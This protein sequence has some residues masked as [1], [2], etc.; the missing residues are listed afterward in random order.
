MEEERLN[1][2]E[3][4]SYIHDLLED[5]IFSPEIESLETACQMCG[6][7]ELVDDLRVMQEMASIQMN[8]LSSENREKAKRAVRPENSCSLETRLETLRQKYA[9]VPPSSEPFRI[10]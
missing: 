5:A 4:A 7:L 9:A 10:M 3:L 6:I 1:F 2:R 8:R